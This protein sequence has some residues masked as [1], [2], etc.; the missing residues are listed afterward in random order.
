MLWFLSPIN[1]VDVQCRMASDL[2]VGGI[3]VHEDLFNGLLF[4]SLYPQTLTDTNWCRLE[5]YQCLFSFWTLVMRMFSFTV[6]LPWAT[7]QFMVS[8]IT[9]WIC[10]TCKRAH[11][12]LF[13][14]SADHRKAIV[15]VGDGRVLKSLISLMGSKSEKVYY[16]SW[17]GKYYLP[18]CQPCQRW[19]RI[20]WQL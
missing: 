14:C 15:A 16:R 5:Q 8:Y 2:C 17:D 6:Q 7:S 12:S 11:V 9:E 4:L 1:M 20:I 18:H 3:D 19:I 10:R 13:L